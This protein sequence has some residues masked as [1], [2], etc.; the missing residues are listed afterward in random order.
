MTDYQLLLLRHA[1]SSWRQADLEDHQRPLNKRGLAAAKR[2]GL[3]LAEAGLRP[4][5]VLCSTA[6]R[7][8]ETWALAAE[9]MGEP[10]PP[11]ALLDDLYHAYPADMLACIRRHGGEARRLLVLGHNP[12][13]EHLAE[14]L[15]GPGS[16]PASLEEMQEKYP[17]SG[18]AVFACSLGAW[19][20]L[21]TAATRL[22]D[23]VTPAK[24]G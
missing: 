9:A 21:T 17:T 11:L 22:L 5:R 16:D 18:L 10:A 8:R 2:M 1:K 4:D 7:T 14:Q 6:L 12:G 23:F 15:A 19:E 3:Y 13:M 20:E 24:L